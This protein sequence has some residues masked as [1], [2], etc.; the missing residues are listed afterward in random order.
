MMESKYNV[1]I[2]SNVVNESTEMQLLG[3]I[4]DCKLNFEIHTAKAY[5]APSYKLSS[6]EGIRKYLTST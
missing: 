2:H 6:L 4:K 3:L 1:L 5:Q